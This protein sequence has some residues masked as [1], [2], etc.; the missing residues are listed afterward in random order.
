MELTME[1]NKKTNVYRITFMALLAAIMCILGP[2]SLP[3]GPVPI[4]LTNL[5]VYL[6]V[7]VLGMADGTVS[8][9][10]YLLLGAVGLPVFS[11]YSGGLGKIAGPTGGYIIGFIFMALIGGFV[12]EKT[13]RKLIPTMAGWVVATAVDYAFGTAWFV[14]IAHYTVIQALAVC[15][16]PFI[17]GDCI[18]I[19][20][21]TLLGR[22]VRKA[23]VHAGLIKVKAKAAADAA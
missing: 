1:K 11:G 15:V 5:A 19:V 4:S 16:F 20:L 13:G 12:L 21:G 17:I 10:L 8:Y 7:Y 6:A 14:Y 2:L 3:I 23:L 18:K 9:C 22:E